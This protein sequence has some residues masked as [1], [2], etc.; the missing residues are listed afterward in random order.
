MTTKRTISQLCDFLEQKGKMTDELRSLFSEF[1]AKKTPPPV[2]SG[3]KKKR[4][5]SAYNKYI[6][7][8][9]PSLKEKGHTPKQALDIARSMWRQQKEINALLATM[10]L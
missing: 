6:Q 10:S 2:E 9:L 7:S 5:T 3:I 8:V 1:A 4:P